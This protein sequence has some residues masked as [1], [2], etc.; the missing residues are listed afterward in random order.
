MSAPLTLAGFAALMAPLGPFGAAPRLGVAVS[1]GADSMALAL[2]ADAWARQRGGA[3]LALTVDHQLRP[4]STAE[5]A[6]VGAWM[7]ARGIAHRILPWTGTKPESDLQAAARAARYGLLDEACRQAGILHCLLAHHREDQAETLLLRLARGSGV[8]GLAAM[9][10]VRAGRHVVW[11]RPLLSVPRAGLAASLRATGQDWVEDPSNADPAYARV[12]LRALGP[13]LAAEGLTPARLAATAG[14]LARARATLDAAVARAVLDFVAV[15]PAGYAVLAAGAFG[16]LDDEIGLR[17][18]AR[19][20]QAMGGDAYAPRLERLE[21]LHA[22]LKGGLSGARTLGGCRLAP[23]DGGR[24]LVCREAA[25]M[26]PPVALAP[27][28]EAAWDGRFRLRLADHAPAGLR[29]GALGS[30]GWRRLRAAGF[31]GG[32]A[33][34]LAVLPAAVRPTLPA[35]HDGDAILAV[36]HL[37][38]NRDGGGLPVLSWIEAATPRPLTVA[39]GCPGGCLV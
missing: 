33:R 26:A 35:I 6:R 25:R 12:R 11:L 8:D 32:G 30:Q 7:A 17:L 36:P 20:L 2:L 31:R 27:G 34:G 22:A 28:Q 1:G 38:Y 23:L 10:P 37:G 9:A 18:L 39:G 3:V 5:A 24:V 16:R 14:R 29:L 4:E 21:G 19:L 15:H 13:V